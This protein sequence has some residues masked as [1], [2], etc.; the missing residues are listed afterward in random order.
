MAEV[1][2]QDGTWTF[3]GDIVRIVPGGG[4]GV[5]KLRQV[6]GEVAVPL[7]AV[8]GLSY[9]PGRKGGWI[10]LRLREG[11]D[12]LTTAAGGRLA[13]AADPWR[14]AVGA[15]RVGVAEYFVDEVRRAV[16]LEQVPSQPCDR[17][18]LPGPAV[19]LTATA[20]DGTAVFDGER[21]R[22]EWNWMTGES[23][24]SAGPR[25]LH[26]GD[27]AG[28]EWYPNHGLEDGFLRFRLKSDPG[29]AQ[30]K[31]DPNCLVMTWGTQKEVGTTVLLAAA[32]T[33]R[34]PHPL[35]GTGPVEAVEAALAAASSA[36]AAGEDYDALLRRLRELGD[37]HRD[38][39]LTDE[40][41]TA[42][43]QMLLGRS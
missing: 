5:H 36:G 16:L 1:M 39:V 32:V 28:V 12:P 15:D 25:Q 24:A 7:A 18:L 2:G 29:G 22:L 6:L 42:A 40:E 9:E 38:G 13:E 23:K 33:A 19:P 35:G 3:D 4:R 8:A 17:F 11:A 34:L 27:L 14:L 30:P 31:H 43:K 37:L 26:V 41:F 10:R 21:I 20:S